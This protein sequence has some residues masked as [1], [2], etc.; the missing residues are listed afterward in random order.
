[1]RAGRSSVPFSAQCGSFPL[2]A[3]RPPC[4]LRGLC[5]N[6]CKGI[7]LSEHRRALI[8]AAGRLLGFNKVNN[9][10]QTDHGGDVEAVLGRKQAL[11][12]FKKASLDPIRGL[13]QCVLGHIIYRKASELFCFSHYV[14][15]QELLTSSK[16]Q[17]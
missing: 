16:F 9:S 5:I 1:M 13:S 14:A 8:S 12:A 15:N 10:K 6:I 4:K 11:K 7:D 2:L 3:H 17:K